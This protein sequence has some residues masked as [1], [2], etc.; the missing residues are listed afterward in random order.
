MGPSSQDIVRSYRT[1]YRQALHAIQ[2]SAPARY[3]LRTLIRHTY[4][5]GSAADFSDQKIKNTLE[6]LNGA[7]R[8]R[9]LEHFIV[10][11]LLHTW[12]WEAGGRRLG[13]E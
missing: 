7:A 1:L 10:K 8:E 9:G 4:R 12:W 3:T 6:F 11:D 5:A 13:S 2:Y